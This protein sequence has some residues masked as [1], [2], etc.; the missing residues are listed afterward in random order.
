MR[1]AFRVNISTVLMKSRGWLYRRNNK[2]TREI[3]NEKGNLENGLG[4]GE[5]LVGSFFRGCNR[6]DKFLN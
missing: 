6:L 2:V 1:A 4:R 5:V 3:Q